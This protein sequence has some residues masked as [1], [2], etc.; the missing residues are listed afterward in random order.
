MQATAHEIVHKIITRGNGREDALYFI[1]TLFGGCRLKSELFLGMC[2]KGRFYSNKPRK[3]QKMPELPEVETVARGIAPFIEGQKITE[4]R[5]NRKDLRTPLPA[6]FKER[7]EG[8]K[9]NKVTRRAK[10]VLCHLTSGEVLIIHLGMSGRLVIHP[11]GQTL[12]N[13]KHDHVIITFSNGVRMRFNDPRRFGL[14]ELVKEN[15]LTKDKLFHHLGPEP[16]EK[17]FNGEYLRVALQARKTPIK[18]AIMNQEVVVGV[19]NIYAAEALYLS[20]IA[21]QRPANKL[22]K[23]EYQALADSIQKILK[24]AIKSGGSTLRDYVRSSG[25]KGY[26]QLSLNVYQREGLPCYCC[27]TTDTLKSS[28]LIRR[29]VQQGRSTFYCSICQK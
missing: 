1:V 24:S 28:P 29:I 7:L 11:K 20:H 4:T 15:N 22:K 3:T 26:F 8:V 13:E 12:P 5:T 17:S 25:D 16:L 2:H 9:V 6:K 21:P 18:T 14:M 23:A 10:Y 19:G 27:A